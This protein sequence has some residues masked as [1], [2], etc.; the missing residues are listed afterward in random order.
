MRTCRDVGAYVCST[1]CVYIYS[2]RR[3]SFSIYSRRVRRDAARS[4]VRSVVDGRQRPRVEAYRAH[5]TPQEASSAPGR[6]VSLGYTKDTPDGVVSS[7]VNRR[8]ES[9]EAGPSLQPPPPRPSKKSE[10]F[11]SRE[12]ETRRRTPRREA[13]RKNQKD[14]VSALARRRKSREI[15]GSVHRTP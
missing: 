7:E 3:T 10:A 6:R 12:R 5:H 8:G 14:C 4:S 15:R 13:R 2:G 9:F 11:S 1:T